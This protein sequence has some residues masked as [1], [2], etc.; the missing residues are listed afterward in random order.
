MQSVSLSNVL[1]KNIYIIILCGFISYGYRHN[2]NVYLFIIF[3]VSI[4]AAQLLLQSNKSRNPSGCK[5]P[6][7]INQ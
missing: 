2:N 3:Y 4:S 1:K 7:M 5:P 6:F